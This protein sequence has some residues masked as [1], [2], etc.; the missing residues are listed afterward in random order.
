MKLYGWLMLST[1]LFTSSLMALEKDRGYFNEKVKQHRGQ[2]QNNVRATKFLNERVDGNRITKRD[3]RKMKRYSRRNPS[4]M[5]AVRKGLKRDGKA[6]KARRR[7]VKGFRNRK[8]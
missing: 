8:K 3:A 1:M 5:R 4:Q 6:R 2:A 7:A